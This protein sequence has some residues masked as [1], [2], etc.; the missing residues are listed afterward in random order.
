MKEIVKFSVTND[1]LQFTIIYRYWCICDKNFRWLTLLSHCVCLR[2]SADS[3]SVN[4]SSRNSA[5]RIWSSG[6]R[7]RTTRTSKPPQA[8][9][10]H[11]R[12]GSLQ[13]SSLI[14]HPEK[15]A[16]QLDSLDFCFL[17]PS[18][19]DVKNVFLHFKN[20]LPRF[21]RFQR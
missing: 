8:T 17:A 2:Q 7:A 5:K 6:S 19:I 4:F 13:N 21:L 20:Y 15:W 18:A 10:L 12:R 14:R 11:R 9:W 16:C 3:V 1:T